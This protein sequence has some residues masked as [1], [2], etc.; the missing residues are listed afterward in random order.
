MRP[1]TSDYTQGRHQTGGWGGG[2]R[3]PPEFW[4]GGFVPPVNPPDF[5]MIFIRG[6]WLPLN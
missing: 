3:N 4:M 1:L 5:K 6:G 2:G